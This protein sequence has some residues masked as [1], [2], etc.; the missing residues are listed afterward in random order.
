M[1]LGAIIR[2]SSGDNSAEAYNQRAVE[3]TKALLDGIENSPQNALGGRSWAVKDTGPGD[4]QQTQSLVVRQRGVKVSYWARPLNDGEP[5]VVSF[6]DGSRW[7]TDFVVWRQLGDQDKSTGQYAG[8]GQPVLADG[9]GIPKELIIGET[10]SWP[11]GVVKSV[12]FGGVSAGAILEASTYAGMTSVER[13]LA[14]PAD[15][16]PH[17]QSPHVS[18]NALIREGRGQLGL[19]PII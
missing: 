5:I 12:S 15:T 16:P 9:T 14:N 2:T 4:L 19:P 11:G 1:R 18:V 8:A 10:L 13:A 3:A 7:A 6:V 17:W